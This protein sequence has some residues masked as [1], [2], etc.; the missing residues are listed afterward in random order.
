MSLRNLLLL[1]IALASAL[2]AYLLLSGAPPEESVEVSREVEREVPSAP[3]AE[4]ELAG[5]GVAVTD[6][7]RRDA[8]EA[9]AADAMMIDHPW[10]EHLAGVTGRIVEEDGSPVVA[11]K[12]ELLEGDL[13]ALLEPEFTA[14]G[15]EDLSAGESITDPD[16][17][18]LIP[19]AV[20]NGLHAFAIDSGGGRSTLRVVEHGLEPGRLT[21]V[22]DIVLPRFVA[23]A[24]IAALAFVV[25]M[26]I[27]YVGAL[28]LS[29][30]NAYLFRQL[31]HLRD[32]KTR[33]EK[34]T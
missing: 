27:A 28:M 20:S 5:A 13:G 3:D 29:V 21:D 25:G 31:I 12:V 18:F 14:M 10:A 1:S 17:R 16:G 6:S 19:G 34:N 2:G 33:A 23:N 22:G 30:G 11:I 4:V 7:G 32:Q 9:T 24:V 26:V 15:H 8:V